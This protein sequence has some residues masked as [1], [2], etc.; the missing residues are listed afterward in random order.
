[1]IVFF[2]ETHYDEKKKTRPQLKLILMDDQCV[3][4]TAVVDTPQL[5]NKQRRISKYFRPAKTKYQQYEQRCRLK[6]LENLLSEKEK[7]SMFHQPC[8]YCGHKHH[9]PVDR[10]RPGDLN[11]IDRLDSNGGYTKE[12]TVS[13]CSRC[14][15]MKGTLSLTEFYTAIR[16]IYHHRINPGFVE[17]DLDQTE[18]QDNNDYKPTLTTH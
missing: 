14:N 11:G 1:M 9:V 16:E 8:F 17:I 3:S 7:I 18:N 13:A 15:Y 2:R 5:I 4:T 12:N 6:T 10:L